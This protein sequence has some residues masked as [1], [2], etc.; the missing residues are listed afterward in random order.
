MKFLWQKRDL[1][2]NVDVGEPLDL[3]ADL[4][5]LTPESLADLSWCSVQSYAGMGF[6]PVEVFDIPALKAEK[7]GQLK[8]EY[9]RIFDGGYPFEIE[10]KAEVLQMRQADLI[11]WLVFKDS[12][13][14]MI[15]AGAGDV[16][17]PLRIRCSSNNAYIVT[18]NR[19]RQIIQGMR[20]YGAGLLSILWA[21]KDAISAATS[22]AELEAVSITDGWA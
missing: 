13:D 20:A 3:P 8:L 21:K 15:A 2:Q 6:F 18:A 1:V 22:V 9:A 19:G 11:N 14:D 16:P 12:C 17:A 5:G 4:R 10:G 7:L